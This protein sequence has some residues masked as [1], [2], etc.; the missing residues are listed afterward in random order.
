VTVSGVTAAGEPLFADVFSSDD[1]ADEAAV[2][3]HKRKLREALRALPAWTGSLPGGNLGA[4]RTRG[5][6][7]RR[8]LRAAGVLPAD[9]DSGDDSDSDVDGAAEEADGKVRAHC[10]HV[11]T[12]RIERACAASASCLS[13]CCRYSLQR[14]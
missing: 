13:D 11:G 9:A 3:L 5:V 10:C 2:V 12:A 8:L 7:S 4:R 14:W 6:V 1:S